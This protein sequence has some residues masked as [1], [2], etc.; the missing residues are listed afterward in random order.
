M[1][2]ISKSRKAYTWALA[3][4]PMLSLYGIQSIGIDIGTILVLLCLGTYMACNGKLIVRA[5]FK[6]WYFYVMYI[7]ISLFFPVIEGGTGGLT[8]SALIARA[9]KNIIYIFILIV[10]TS[11]NVVEYNYYKKVY[12]FLAKLSSYYIILQAVFYYGLNWIIPGYINKFLM[13]QEYGDRLSQKNFLMYR[14]TSLFYE[15]SHYFEFVVIALII[16]LFENR[17]ISR[18]NLIDAVIITAGI[19][20]STSG[21]G[22]ITIVIIWALWIFHRLIRSYA[23]TMESRALFIIFI[24]LISG[25]FFLQTGYAHSILNRLFTSDVNTYSATDAR[26]G[27]YREILNEEIFDLVLGNGYGNVESNFY[28]PSWAFNLWCLGLIGTTIILCIYIK[29]FISCTRIDTKI[30]LFVNAFL[31]MGTTLFMGKNMLLYF[32][33]IM[34]QAAEEKKC[35]IN[36]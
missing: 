11:G 29:Y 24:F 16:Y 2:G 22:I 25:I 6:C 7:L 26:T 14:P 1:K 4:L 10:S 12:L 32:T 13:V 28:Y 18:K 9:V 27:V 21:M 8:R 5:D 17:A 35:R 23:K 34:L 33:F 36:R 19:L 31:C 15:P 3:L 20:A 30:I